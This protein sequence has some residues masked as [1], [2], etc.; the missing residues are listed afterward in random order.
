MGRRVISISNDRDMV[1]EN[2]VTYV[3]C[4]GYLHWWWAARQ[5][6][7]MIGQNGIW[8]ILW[9]SEPFI[10]LKEACIGFLG[11]IPEADKRKFSWF[12]S[13]ILIKQHWCP[14]YF[15]G[16][17]ILE[18]P[19]NLVLSLPCSQTYFEFLCSVIVWMGLWVTFALFGLSFMSTVHQKHD[20]MLHKEC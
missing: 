2:V 18:I 3:Y 11:C 15:W 20:F 17:K 14:D 1:D 19:E 7:I 12:L 8:M 13:G 16:S 4:W 10:P 6:A 5:V 9:A